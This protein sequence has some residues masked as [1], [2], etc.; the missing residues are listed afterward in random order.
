MKICVKEQNLN[1]LEGFS[2][3]KSMPDDPKDSVVYGARTDL[4]DSFI[5]FFPI[6]KQSSMPYGNAKAVIDGIH[7]CLD[8]DQGL[9]EVETGSTKSGKS[10][11]YSIVK[12]AMN[13][14]GVQYTLTF[15]YDLPDFTL[16]I[17]AF[18][19]EKGTTGLRDSIVYEQAKRDGI[20][21][22]DFDGWMCDPYDPDYKKGF[23]MNLS[24]QKHLDQHFQGHV[25]TELRKFIDYFV[26]NN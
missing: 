24:E 15:H 12:S 3:V 6:D 23:L 1:I 13:P 7:G 17:R 2:N 25:L 26:E 22:G 14:H 5:L 21:S 9:I 8:E 19:T 16:N 18:Y 20:V 11:I 4:F 10:Y